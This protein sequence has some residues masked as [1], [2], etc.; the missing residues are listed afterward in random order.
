MKIFLKTFLGVLPVIVLFFIFHLPT[1]QAYP[2]VSTNASDIRG[3][4]NLN[5]NGW[6][7]SGIVGVPF[8]SALTAIGYGSDDT[9]CTIRIK[10]APVDTL[11][12]TVNFAATSGW[13]RQDCP[14][15][16]ASH[17]A[18]T[19]DYVPNSFIVGWGWGAK[20]SGGIPGGFSGTPPNICAYQQYM[21][22]STG[23]VTTG[24]FLGTFTNNPF[25]GSCKAQGYV[26]IFDLQKFV[27]A[28]PGEVIVAINFDVD[29]DAKLDRLE[30]IYD[31]QVPW[32]KLD[33]AN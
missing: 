4:A 13:Q 21:N 12:A 27:S 19:L 30:A 25:V 33:A 2:Y 7:T 10:T 1:A 6:Q 20:T 8:G 22:L 18:R 23:V 24:E 16:P 26:T 29:N 17:T 14:D 11:T 3:G 28:P 5:Q 9:K 15:G 31:T 32:S